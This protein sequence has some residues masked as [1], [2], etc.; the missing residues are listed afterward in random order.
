MFSVR[1]DSALV[2]RGF[3]THSGLSSDDSLPPVCSAR[4]EPPALL[5]IDPMSLAV[6]RRRGFGD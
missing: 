2:G 6:S 3:S 5:Y 4:K 1:V